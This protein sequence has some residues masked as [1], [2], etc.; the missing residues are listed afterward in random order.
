[1][2]GRFNQLFLRTLRELRDLRRYTP[3]VVVQHAGQIN[4]AGQQVNVAGATQE[5]Q[6]WLTVG[7]NMAHN[8]R[9]KLGGSANLGTR[10]PPKP[11]RMHWRTYWRL[12]Q[13]AEAAEETSWIAVQA[14]IDRADARLAKLGLGIDDAEGGQVGGSSDKARPH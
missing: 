8:I 4:V 2:C 5:S 12:R 3:A 14:S 7:C 13:T 11:P 1:M 6:G 10:F 9:R